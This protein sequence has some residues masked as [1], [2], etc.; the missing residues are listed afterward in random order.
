[1]ARKTC[2]KCQSAMIEG[3]VVDNGH[4]TKS[5]SGWIE[6]LP[7]KSIWTGLKL[8]GRKP[9]DIATWRCGSCGFL[10]SYAGGR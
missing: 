7:E 1:M 6:G 8:R 4:G 2:P 9:I 3:F 10:E 5:V